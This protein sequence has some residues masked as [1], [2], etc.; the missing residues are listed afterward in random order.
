M[1]FFREIYELLGNDR[2]L[3]SLIR[4]YEG[5]RK[6]IINTNC[7]ILFNKTCIHEH[8][9]PNYSNI[10]LNDQ[11]MHNEAGNLRM[12]S[13][14]R[15]LSEAKTKLTFLNTSLAEVNAELDLGIIPETLHRCRQILEEVINTYKRKEETRILNKLNRLY[16]GQILLPQNKNCYLN[17]SEQILTEDEKELLNLGTNC[18]FSSKFDMYIKQTELEI[19]YESLRNLSS[20]DKITLLPGLRDQLRAEASKNRS[21]GG[22]TL[23]TPGLREAGKSLKNNKNIIIQKADKSNMFVVMD[24]KIQNKCNPQRRN[25]I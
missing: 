17:L 20:K 8:L 19:L 2:T 7:A 25:Q 21:R 24:R 15:Q 3:I 18:H 9:L 22:S 14:K 11:A 16:Q 6:K 23:L 1:N 5:I 13:V 12:E 4:K 10:R